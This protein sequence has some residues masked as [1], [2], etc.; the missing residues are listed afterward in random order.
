MCLR[1]GIFL[2][3][4]ALKHVSIAM[5]LT[6]VSQSALNPSINLGLTKPSPNS[7]DLE[8][9]VVAVVVAVMA[10]MGVDA[11]VV[12][13]MGVAMAIKPTHMGSGKAMPRL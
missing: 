13:D 7:L 12:Q 8:A 3:S 11:D 4:T 1:N 2:K 5:I 9:D 10:A 6:M